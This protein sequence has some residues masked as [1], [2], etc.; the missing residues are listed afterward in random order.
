MRDPGWRLHTLGLV[1]TLA[2]L[3]R[4]ARADLTWQAPAQCP[5]AAQVSS[6]IE[7]LLAG[8]EYPKEA[9]DDFSLTVTHEARAGVFVV[10]ITRT[11]D[12]ARQERVVEAADCGELTGRVG[13]L[14]TACRSG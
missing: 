2:M 3:T 7:R 9:L 13:S 1:V 10:R 6:E 14:E 5:P 4:T 8:S 12:G 11:Q